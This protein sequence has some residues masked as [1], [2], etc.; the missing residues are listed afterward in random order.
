MTHLNRLLSGTILSMAALLGL[1]ACSS[2][3]TQ[4]I[5][6]TKGKVTEVV[7]GRTIKLSNNL[8]VRLLGVENN[9]EAQ[10]FLERNVKG[11]RVTLIAD[12]KDSKQSFTKGNNAVVNAYVVVPGNKELNSVNGSMIR[13]KVTPVRKIGVNDSIGPFTIEDKDI[14]LPDAEILALLKPRTFLI[15]HPDGSLG[16]GFYISSTGVALTN[17]HVLNRSNMN[18]ARVIPFNDDGSYDPS[19]YRNIDRIL[20]VGSDNQTQTDYC[21]FQVNLNGEKVPFLNLAKEHEVDGKKVYKLGCVSGEPAHFSSGNIS[22]TN[23]GVV[24]HSSKTNQGDSG[25]PLVNQAG[26]V[27]GINQ[28]IKVNPNIGGDVGVYYAVDIQIL[29]DWF[30]NHRDDQ[31]QL[32]YG[33]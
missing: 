16:T 10:K 32:R 14:I 11:K 15:L 2:T 9:A 3:E 20:T 13:T 23:D 17:A 6:G 33:R 21:V 25:S 29:R 26:K 18:G 8:T 22:H 27:I 31:G 30:E 12:S 28:S 4:K 7:D 24:S 5:T 1:N 19:N